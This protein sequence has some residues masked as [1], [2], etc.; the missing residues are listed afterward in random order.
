MLNIS[1]AKLNY[2]KEQ[3]P[4]GY[5]VT[6][7]V[8]KHKDI[9][10]S[11]TL[12]GML[13][14]SWYW[15]NRIITQLEYAI[16]LSKVK[17]NH[18]EEIINTAIDFIYRNYEKDKTLTKDIALEVEKMLSSLSQEAKSFKII[19]AAHAH[20]DMNWMWRYDETVSVILETFHTILNLMNEYPDFK[21][22]QSQASVYKIL[23]DYAHE[24]LNQV[25]KRVKEGRWEV[26][27]ST[28][29]ENDK[30]MPN[31]ESM[32]RHLLY[33]KQYLS[34]LLEIDPD[35]LKIDFEPDT[36]GHN[37]NMPEILT[38]GGVKYYYHCRG[39]E[40]YNLSKWIAPSKKY[41]IA[42]REP[43]WYNSPIESS[44]ALN[45]PEF[46]SKYH[47]DTMLK[48]YGVGDHGGGPTRRD[49]ERIID[50][51]T[52]PVFPEIRF[53]TFSEYFSLVEEIVDELPEV[54]GERNF[55]FTGCYTSQ[56]R[57]KKAN[58]VS[59]AILN[60]AETFYTI[61]SLFSSLK[62]PSK[63]FSEAWKNVLFNQFHDILPGS[64]TID[65]REYAMGL[66][67]QTTAIANTLRS[68]SMNS[69][70]EDIDTSS[71]A[72]DK[73]NTKESIS[74]GAGVGYGVENLKVTQ[75]ERGSGMKRIFHIFNP[76][77]IEREE[78][79]E[80][81]VWDW[82]GDIEKIIVKDE[83]DNI[84]SYQ[85]VDRT[86]QSY[87]GHNYFRLLI[88]A[89]VP[90]YGY[91][92]Y[93]LSEL[94]DNG[95]E[96]LPSH[97][98][99]LFGSHVE[100]P[101]KFILENNFIK[102]TFDSRNA[103]LVSLIDK[104][105]NQEMINTNRSAAIFRLIEEEAKEFGTAW[106]VGRYMNIEELLN[107]VKIKQVHLNETIRKSF[108]YEISFRNSKITVTAS[109][110]HNSS[111]LK[112]DVQCDWKEYGKIDDRVPQLGFYFPLSYPPEFFKYD[113]PFGVIKRKAMDIDVV[114]N[115]FAVGVNKNPQA[116]S[117][118]LITDSKYGFRC[119]D[120]SMSITLLRSSADPDPYP[121]VGIHKFSFALSLISVKSNKELLDKAY[122]FNH[123]L[124][125]ITGTFHKGTL[126][127]SKSF[128]TLE[129]GSIVVSA[130]KFPE[131]EDS[132]K[133]IVRV[134]ETDGEKTTAKFEF[135]REVKKAYFV[136]INE[137]FSETDRIVSTDDNRVSFEVSPYSVATL[138]VEFR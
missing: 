56:S 90:A 27:A 14:D 135:F 30:N 2:L 53:G 121:E 5:W 22:S 113:V 43:F 29:V 77:Q 99:N 103:S 1:I 70:V 35:S 12:L 100:S 138:C 131:K 101:Y 110:D 132:D 31:G 62:Y 87:W 128:F 20:I 102:A 125:F 25:K 23:E 36:F 67:Q 28:W 54:E 73:K 21:F 32:A 57:I 79:V 58:R 97:L 124:N 16:H 51:N 85:L 60:E 75:A 93:I 136:D 106:V 17:N 3:M 133:I 7:S 115:S 19:C 80:I 50:M 98:S 111:A 114:A 94:E 24:T 65:S 86:F 63:K 105:N 41:V 84:I 76:A 9:M 81:T 15:S 129:G 37:I 38:K 45:V 39:Y 46:C 130:I 82:E 117:I 26:T 61:S 72:Q 4:S 119:N 59:E 13:F 74:E 88:D 83:K 89:K 11:G 123:P 91:S 40:G 78:V 92:T 6:E 42:Y 18:F 112:F 52:W 109:L 8:L 33:T 55:I 120:D 127:L 47:M 66:F 118:M 10:F 134:Y 64:C 95:L 71:L 68:F 126:P 44:M 107:N 104:E 69:I 49:I 122:T 137:K 48:V 116:K 34:N 96:E 108:S